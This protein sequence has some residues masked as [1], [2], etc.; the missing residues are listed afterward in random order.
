M[1]DFFFS[2]QPIAP[3]S[4]LKQLFSLAHHSVVE[5][6]SHPVNDDEYQLLTG[7]GRRLLLG[8]VTISDGYIVR[9][10]FDSSVQHATTM[11]ETH[12]RIH[13]KE[14]SVTNHNSV[15]SSFTSDRNMCRINM[16][17]HITVCICTYKRPGLLDSLLRH[18]SQQRTGD[19]FTYSIVISD[20]DIDQSGRAIAEA[21]RE[22]YGLSIVYCV[23]PHQN[24]ALARNAAVTH[25]SGDF[26]AFIDDDEFPISDWL[27]CLFITLNG[28][29][30]DGVLGP[31]KRYFD[32]TP[33]RWLEKS[34]FYVRPILPTG[35]PVEWQ[36]SR[37]GNVLLKREIVAEDPMPFRPQFRAGE[38]NDFFRRQIQAGRRFIWCDD[39]DVF[40][41]VPPARW[42]RRYLMKKALLRGATA[43]LQA[44]M[45]SIAKSIIAVPV[46][47]ITLPIA[48]F[49]GQ[50]LVM[51]QL[52][53]LCDHIG[54]LLVIAGINPIREPYISDHAS[55]PPSNG[56][57]S[58]DQRGHDTY[59]APNAFSKHTQ[60][61]ED[62]L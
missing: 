36:E 37:S 27:L 61:S 22:Q 6:E 45:K 59:H 7:D 40:E 24:I 23:E 39:A 42:S 56:L 13:R 21:A 1:T 5:V 43:A 4:R 16:Q 49:G 33:P 18:L 12:S 9:K 30:V 50:T 2:L 28:Y 32:R 55:E 62:S 53:K 17:P 34:T 51:T 47:V 11:G 3:A 15:A 20:N 35:T 41:L 48:L 10:T 14:R 58:S 26:L 60:S 46:Y 57:T 31:V 44:D 54:K 25:A 29:A 8:D 19:L 38:D 52:V